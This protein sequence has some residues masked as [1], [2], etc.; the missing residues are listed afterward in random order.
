MR[1][2]RIVNITIASLLETNEL[3]IKSCDCRKRKKMTSFTDLSDMKMTR[4]GY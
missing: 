3:A 2:Q 4:F 1:C